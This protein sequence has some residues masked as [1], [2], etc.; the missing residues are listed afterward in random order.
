MVWKLA[1]A[2]S[3]LATVS[4]TH[5]FL[6]K[7]QVTRLRVVVQALNVERKSRIGRIGRKKTENLIAQRCALAFVFQH[8]AHARIPGLRARVVV[9]QVRKNLRIFPLRLDPVLDLCLLYTSQPASG[10]RG[11]NRIP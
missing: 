2:A 7:G 8:I 5:L 3:S 10:K 6:N 9:V 1:D 4:Y 11:R